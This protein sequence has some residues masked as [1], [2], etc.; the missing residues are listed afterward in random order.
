MRGQVRRSYSSRLVNR[1]AT[2]MGSVIEALAGPLAKC[3]IDNGPGWDKDTGEEVEINGRT[4]LTGGE[5]PI[6]S[7]RVDIV[8]EA[9]TRG[10][11]GSY[12]WSVILVPTVMGIRGSAVESAVMGKGNRCLFTT[13]KVLR[14]TSCKSCS[15]AIYARRDKLSTLTFSAAPVSLVRLRDSLVLSAAENKVFGALFTVIRPG[16]ESDLCSIFHKQTLPS[17]SGAMTFSTLPS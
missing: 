2:H 8:A 3:R 7:H 14:S 4:L 13:C 17:S 15:M 5:P 11:L 6:S 12:K 9:S 16:S 10:A 1:P